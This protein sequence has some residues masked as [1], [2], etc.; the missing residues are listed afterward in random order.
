MIFHLISGLALA[1]FCIGYALR[2][3]RRIHIP[4]MLAA[5]LT[6]LAVVIIL[7]I[8]R[9]PFGT[10]A[11]SSPGILWVHVSLALLSLVL[12]GRQA[13][14][15]RRLVGDPAARASHGRLAVTFLACRTLTFITALMVTPA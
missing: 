6:D 3:R 1:A 5:G 11:R 2:R 10:L 15:G 8:Q 4:L 14:T 13:W 9:D 7:T 12:L